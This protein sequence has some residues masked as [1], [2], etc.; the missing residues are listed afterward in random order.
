RGFR[1]NP[2]PPKQQQQLAD[3]SSA[4]TTTKT[5]YKAI[6]HPSI[7]ISAKPIAEQAKEWARSLKLQERTVGLVRLG[8]HHSEALQACDETA[9]ES[10]T[11]EDEKQSE[12]IPSGFDPAVP[13][14]LKQLRQEALADFKEHV[15]AEETL[16]MALEEQT[17]ELEALQAIYDDQLTIIRSQDAQCEGES[18]N[19]AVQQPGSRYIIAVKPTQPIPPPARSDDCRLHVLLQ[20]GYPYHTIPLLLLVNESLPPT[21][22]RRINILLHQKAQ[23]LLGSPVVFEMVSFLENDLP[24]HYSAFLREQRRKEFEAEQVR[25]LRQRKAE[26]EETERIMDMQYHAQYDPNGEGTKV[27]R[28]QRA[29]LK[30]AEKAYD[31]PDQVEELYKEYRR[32]QDVRVEDAQQ[33][34]AQVRATYA[35]LAI[36]RRQQEQIQEEAETAARSAMSAA[37]NRGEDV[38][39]AREVAK[40]ARYRVFQEH[41]ISIPEEGENDS[42]ATIDKAKETEENDVASNQDQSNDDNQKEQPT[43]KSSQ[44]MDRLRKSCGETTIEEASATME[45]KPK[46][47]TQQTSAFMDR[48]R[49]MYDGAVQNKLS[50]KTDDISAS[51]DSA[52]KLESYHLDSPNEDDNE[53]LPSNIPR[54]VAVASGELVEVMKDIIDQQEDQPWLVADEARA[55]TLNSRRQTVSGKHHQRESDISKRLREELERKQ[56]LALEWAMKNE[57]SPSHMNK[58]KRQN[59]NNGFSPEK[60]HHLMNVRQ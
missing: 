18:T 40:Q 36:E 21:F 54:P 24:E 45:T 29:K 25:L 6:P 51:E 16:E 20:E 50:K 7:S 43:A 30:A 14:L 17:Q 22:L 42:K 3:G 26:M 8:F 5:I 31:R 47:P 57:E 48:L 32:K 9:A 41:G 19:D 53:Q 4:S 60:Y 59:G 58:G 27:G 52:S 56:R 34:N 37:F 2:N 28:R 15:E 38:E 39:A 33:Q 11:E 23:E 13:L 1:P 35:Q 44:F 12:S 10:N 55:P 46:G 49:A